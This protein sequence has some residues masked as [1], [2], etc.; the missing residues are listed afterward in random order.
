MSFKQQFQAVLTHLKST[1]KIKKN[2]IFGPPLPRASTRGMSMLEIL[3]VLAIIGMIMGMVAVYAGG[4]FSDSQVD[5]AKNEITTLESLVD[6]Y[7]LKKKGQCPKSFQDLKSAGITKKNVKADPWGTDYKFK[8]PGDHGD[9]DIWSS[10]PDKQEGSEDD[11]NNW[12]ETKKE[13][14]K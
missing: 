4:A 2:V 3:V 9:V 6:M 7:K 11:I 1:G 5:T 8:C 13:E 14:Q 12:E 10:G